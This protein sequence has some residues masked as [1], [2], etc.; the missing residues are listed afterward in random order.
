MHFVE[1]CTLAA[2]GENARFSPK[3]ERHP[4]RAAV[5]RVL[6]LSPRVLEKTLCRASRIRSVVPDSSH[7]ICT[8]HATAL[9]SGHVPAHM[10]WSVCQK[11]AIAPR[12]VMAERARLEG[13]QLASGSLRRSLAVRQAASRSSTERC[14]RRRKGGLRRCSPSWR[15]HRHRSGAD[16]PR[17][18][19]VSVSSQ[20]LGGSI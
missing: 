17:D 16:L 12:A 2:R 7:Q 8:E 5:P 14:C 13:E 10:M 15:S 6:I 4:G 18:R 3:R 1:T 11:D 19:P 20:L 9:S